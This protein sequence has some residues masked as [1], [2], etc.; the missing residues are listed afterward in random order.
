M[1]SSN[2]LYADGAEKKHHDIAIGCLCEEFSKPEA[3]IRPIYEEILLEMK[4]EA[5]IKQFL[6]ILVCRSI[7]D[8]L[9][10]NGD[11]PPL[12]LDEF[13]ANL[14]KGHILSAIGPNLPMG[15]DH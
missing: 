3:V 13:H 1:A 7:R 2:P 15:L 14:F 10:G 4:T 12:W 9:N 11:E 8:L 5:K 6:S